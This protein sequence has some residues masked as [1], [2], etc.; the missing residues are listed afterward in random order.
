MKKYVLTVLFIQLSMSSN[1]V[2]SDAAMIPKPSHQMVAWQ[3]LTDLRMSL[4]ERGLINEAL[5]LYR[6]ERTRLPPIERADATLWFLE[7]TKERTSLTPER[8]IWIE[9]EL[10]IFLAQSFY[11]GREAGRGETEFLRA[12]ELLDA[13]CELFH[14]SR[15]E[16]LTPRLDIKLLR[17]RYR[18]NDDGKAQFE[19]SV[20]LLQILKACCHTSTITCYHQAT[21]AAYELALKDTTGFY[22]D[23]FFRLH[24]EQEIYQETVQEDAR[25]LLFDQQ[26]FF[27]YAARNVTDLQKALE[28]LDSFLERYPGFNLPNGLMSIHQTRKIAYQRFGDPKKMAQEEAEI[29]KLK[30]TVPERI[31]T[32][33]GVRRSKAPST[34]PGHPFSNSK[35]ELKF[36]LDIEEENFFTDWHHAAGDNETKR[37]LALQKL[38]EWIIIDLDKGSI[39]AYEVSTILAIQDFE[40]GPT[41]LAQRLKVIEPEETFAML[42]LQSVSEQDTPLSPDDWEVRSDTLERWLSRDQGPIDNGRQYLR[43]IL[44]EIRKDTVCKSQM[45]LDTKILELEK[46][47]SMVEQLPPRVKEI[48]IERTAW[49]HGSIADQIYL[50]CCSSPDQFDSDDIGSYIARAETECQQSTMEYQAQGEVVCAAMRQRLTAELCVMKI[51]WLQQRESEVLKEVDLDKIRKTGLRSLDEAESYFAL[52]RQESTWDRDLEGLEQRERATYSENSWR[53]PQI[54]M[55]LLNAGKAQ[56]DESRRIELWRWVQR[57][58]ARSLA[59]SMGLGGVIPEPL[60]KDVLASEGCRPMYEKMVS[61]QSQILSAQSHRRFALRYELDLH[62]KEMKNHP[63][64]KEVCDLKDGMPLTLSDLDRITGVANATLVL[65]DWYVVPDLFGEG[66]LLLLTAKARRPPTVTTLDITTRAP[67][68]W[69]TRHLDSSMSQQRSKDTSDLNALVQPLIDLTEP[70]DVLVF[71][72]SAALHRIPLHAIEVTDKASSDWCP[73]TYRNPIVYSHSHS[74]LRICLWNAQLASEVKVPLKPL[75]MN[76]IP[77]DTEIE[78]YTAGRDS[79]K[80]LAEPFNTTALLDETAT[81]SAFTEYAPASRLIHIHSHVW[82]DASNPLEHHIVLNHDKLTAREVFQITFPKG[83]HVSLIACSG[84]RARVGD[85]DEVMGLVPALLHSGASSTVST[86][87]GIPDTIGAKFTEAFYQ[88]FFEQRRAFPGSK[89]FVNLARVFQRAIIELAFEEQRVSDAADVDPMLH[90]TSFVMHG[91][92]DFFVPRTEQ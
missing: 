53:V 20:Q 67:I 17:L 63:L 13:W 46:C 50:H 59:T 44:Q 34:P 41:S 3:G 10:R 62:L 72:P 1:Y 14:Y 43:S 88:K 69:V 70:G 31:G 35:A 73:I 42:Y 28:W 52:K 7:Y 77:R 39:S 22:L 85:G 68:D 6:V 66:T 4:L 5:S 27:Q 74:L 21:E 24:Q 37:L 61:L 64:L 51:H 19:E 82:W 92:W 90:W 81:K 84:G 65:V 30:D 75:I 29:K 12:E 45:A 49:W 60:L 38:L 86:L 48:V 40:K 32:L 87:W 26:D 33:V 83:T 11:E 8:S 71:S 2:G 89:G 57:A 76:G 55:Q 80:K 78:R 56:A 16:T 36:A 54:A 23:Q 47:I 15:R 79:A 58:K 25:D 18:G 9:M 91:F